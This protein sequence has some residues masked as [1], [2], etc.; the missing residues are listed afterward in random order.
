MLIVTIYLDY[1][2]ENYG[3]SF[4]RQAPY[5]VF[6]NFN[7]NKKRNQLVKQWNIKVLN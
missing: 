4:S 7:T 5:L 3:I 2:L 6:F 1:F